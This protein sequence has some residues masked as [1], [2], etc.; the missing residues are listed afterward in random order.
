[1]ESILVDMVVV[2]VNLGLECT[3]VNLVGL[4]G[5]V[6]IFDFIYPDF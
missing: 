6:L 1:M 4:S 5:N 3:D 2:N